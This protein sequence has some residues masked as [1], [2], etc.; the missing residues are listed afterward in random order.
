[1]CYYVNMY[2][3]NDI[4]EMIKSKDLDPYLIL[5][6]TKK[7][8][9]DISDHELK[10]TYKR[11]ALILHP[12]KTGGETEAEFKVLSVCYK[13]ILKVR[14]KYSKEYLKVKNQ[15]FN[16]SYVADDIVNVS[17]DTDAYIKSLYDSQATIHTDFGNAENRKMY[18]VDDDQEDESLFIDRNASKKQY[19]SY[20]SALRDNKIDN[21]LTKNGKQK[22]NID[23]FNAVFNKYNENVTKSQALIKRDVKDLLLIDTNSVQMHEIYKVDG[24]DIIIHDPVKT[25]DLHSLNTNLYKSEPE[26]VMTAAILKQVKRGDIKQAK[27]DR[28]NKNAMKKSE[29]KAKINEYHKSVNDI[30]PDDIETEEQMEHSRRGA[31]FLER[32]LRI[33]PKAIQGSIMKKLQGKETF[34]LE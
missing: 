23:K 12:D 34:Y 29:I 15:L 26:N 2:K 7:N 19:T 32:N 20:S 3:T 22:F 11:R 13:Y 18:F 24:T 5:G 1:M 31:E 21:F 10:K 30:N 25:K 33:F 6:L 16:K 27:L 17:V 28:V 9:V 8:A 14:E 4:V